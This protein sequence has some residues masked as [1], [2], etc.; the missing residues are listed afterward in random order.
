MYKILVADSIASEGLDVFKEYKDIQVDVKTGLPQEELLKII[1]E[2]DGLVVRSATKFK[3][4]LVEKADKMKVVGRAG[5]GVDN[6]DVP[7]SS[8]KGIVVMNT[9]GG[10]SEAAAELSIAMITA[11]SRNI[12]QASMSMKQGKWEKS[13]F[14]KTSVEVAGKTLGVVGAGNIGSIVANRGLG[15]QMNVLV[16]DPFLSEEKA[17]LMGIKKVETL[18]EIYKDSDYITLHLPKN[19]QTLNLINKNTIAKMKDGVYLINCARGGI[20]NEQDLLEALNSGKVKAAGLDVFDKEPVDP[21]NPLVAHPS[22]IC[23]PHLGASTVEA[24]VNVAVAIARQMGDYLTTG[25]IR[26]AVN[27]PNIDSPTRKVITPY[28]NLARKIGDIYRQF[29]NMNITEIE[30]EYAGEV[31]NLPI[32]PI[33]HSLLIGLLSDIS[34]GI[35]FVNAPVIAKERGI[36]I[37]ESKIIESQDYASQITLTAHHKDGTTTITGAVFK[38]GIIRIVKIDDFRIDINPEGN[39]LLTINEDKPGFIGAIGTLIGEAGLNIANMELGRNS[40]KTEALSFIQIDGEIPDSLID[41]ISKNIKVL[42]K[43]FR[44]KMD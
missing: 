39:L 32:N 18:D 15:L 27:L 2:Y 42:K 7:L 44:I 28:I 26:N 22:V 43:I 24:Q 16:Y 21:D 41:K 13:K 25:E 37:T 5:A 38:E 3:G 20:V 33:N 29:A 34:E 19:E 4:E 1:H 23:T 14:D 9:P 17:I 30:I 8:K 6:I 10:N 36:K 35:N 40:K 31:Y 11:L 12:V